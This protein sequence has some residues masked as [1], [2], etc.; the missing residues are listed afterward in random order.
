VSWL[1][2]LTLPQLGVL[3]ALAFGLLAWLHLRA[4]R[5][6]RTR[7]PYLGA[8]DEVAPAGTTR[9]VTWA[10][11]RTWAL[12]RALAI[13]G[14]LGVALADPQPAWLAGKARTTLV[15]LDAGA[16]M[17]AM[18]ETPSRFD[19]ARTRAESVVA[20]SVRAGEVM[21]AQLDAEVTPL[22]GWERQVE[23]LTAAARAAAVSAVETRFAALA[24][25]A[26]DQLRSKPSPE[27]IVVTDGAFEV[28]AAELKSLRD[29][30]IAISQVRVGSRADN[31]AI[32][33][34]ALRAYPWDAERCEAMVELENTGGHARSVELT[35]IEDD[36]PI[37]V[38]P[39]L[40]PA[41]SRTTHFFALGAS[42][43]R[44]VARIAAQD[45]TKDAQPLDDEAYAVVPQRRS[46]RVLLVT[47]GQRYLESALAL[48][49]KLE[50]LE[51][52]PAEYQSADG[53]DVAIFDRFVPSA[54]PAVPALWIAPSEGGP[55]RIKG[56][57]DRPF[58]DEVRA[59][60]PLLKT[61]SLRDVNIRR[62]QRVELEPGDEI[63]GRSKQGPLIVQG[64]RSDQRF[65]AFTFD[66][67]E[68][69]LVLRT[70]WPVLV[71]KA[72]QQLTASGEP[73]FEP[74]LTVGTPTQ[75][76]VSDGSALLQGPT[77]E[78]KTLAVR[79]GA[80]AFTPTRPGFYELSTPTTKH[81]FA[82]SPNAEATAQIKP[83]RFA[84]EPARQTRV[85]AIPARDAVWWASL[86]LALALLALD[87]WRLGRRHA[88]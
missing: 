13:V 16:H 15:V 29:L 27:L 65:L 67:R 80:V 33:Q 8:W 54:A 47:E 17:Q 76:E 85:T 77:G 34:F 20:A 81:P 69:D 56:T 49:P 62:A 48:D 71:A 40:L 50:V 63:L 30:G 53:F 44:F 12:L 45:A 57:I 3:L 5:P 22:S 2:T 25:F 19:Q 21:L 18:D 68:S 61:L 6:V 37:D 74:S 55:L 52:K 32:R 87:T 51:Q 86:A 70:A 60:H 78:R 42:G 72:I 84:A 82:V 38:K 7:V 88:R 43:T 39:L 4:P 36:K 23:P 1:G 73:A 24:A 31:L 41:S 14:L 9:P 35:L 58:F 11:A 10:L 59:D 75:F 26:R 66:A 28:P 79:N 83:A 64:T 46:R